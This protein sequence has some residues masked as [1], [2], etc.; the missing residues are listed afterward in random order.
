MIFN[1]KDFSYEII[2][3]E[4]LTDTVLETELNGDRLDF[5]LTATKDRPKYIKLKW[6]TENTD[7]FLVLGD[8]W[9]RTYGNL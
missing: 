5:Y 2:C 3:D 8:A 1:L 4:V 7:G 9:E 6:N